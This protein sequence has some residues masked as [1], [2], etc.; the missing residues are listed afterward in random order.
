MFNGRVFLCNWNNDWTISYLCNS[1]TA[2]YT[3]WNVCSYYIFYDILDYLI[4]SGNYTGYE[5]LLRIVLKD[6]ILLIQNGYGSHYIFKDLL[7]LLGEEIYKEYYEI[8]ENKR[9]N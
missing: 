3:V 5:L 1:I 2:F 8:Y 4:V 9:F 6:G 7:P